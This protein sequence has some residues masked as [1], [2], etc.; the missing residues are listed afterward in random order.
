MTLSKHILKLAVI[1]TFGVALFQIVITLSPAWSLYFGAG[2]YVTS[3][4]WLLYSSGIY[5]AILF[6]AFGLY[7]F[8]GVGSVRKLPLLRTG[9]ILIGIVFTLR[10]LALVPSFLIN[11]GYFQTRIRIPIQSLISSAVSL[12]IGIIYIIGI[13]GC[14]KSLSTKSSV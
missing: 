7:A 13:V 2:E 10:G 11:A 9:L 6:I 4:L 14:W 12:F 1:L 8:S 3:R 5:V